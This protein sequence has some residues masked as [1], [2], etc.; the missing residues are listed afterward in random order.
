MGRHKN[1]SSNQNINGS[2]AELV[3]LPG[4]YCQDRP[5]SSELLHLSTT[6]VNWKQNDSLLY[7]SVNS[8]DLW[9][10]PM[11]FLLLS[12]KRLGGTAAYCN[13]TP[14]TS[15]KASVLGIS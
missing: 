7:S 5:L 8:S 15:F 14:G 3:P 9:K 6:L 4:A 12:V 10:P 13:T 2:E 11:L 1:E